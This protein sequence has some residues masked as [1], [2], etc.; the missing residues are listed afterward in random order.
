MGALLSVPREELWF[1]FRI[2]SNTVLLSRYCPCISG[3]PKAVKVR[4][5]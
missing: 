4:Q 3:K 1:I 2:G 5:L